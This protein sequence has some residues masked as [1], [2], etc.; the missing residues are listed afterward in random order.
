MILEQVFCKKR[1]C[2]NIDHTDSREG[3]SNKK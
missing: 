2:F 3:R 1:A